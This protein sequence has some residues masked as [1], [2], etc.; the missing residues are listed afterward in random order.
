MLTL[1]IR[2]LKT[3]TICWCFR[4]N[5]C[6]FQ[7]MTLICVRSA[8]SPFGFGTTRFQSREEKAKK[9]KQLLDRSTFHMH[10]HLFGFCLTFNHNSSLVYSNFSCT[11]KFH[12][13]FKCNFILSNIMIILCRLICVFVWPFLMETLLSII[14]LNALIYQWHSVNTV[15]NPTF[16]YTFII[17]NFLNHLIANKITIL[18]AKVMNLHW[19]RLAFSFWFFSM[20]IYEIPFSF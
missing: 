4:C 7:S 19:N 10:K 20:Q 6:N 14:H 13:I 12:V 16:A 11:W 3:E 18:V 9:R 8:T 17:L 5:I 15:V 1:M 2:K